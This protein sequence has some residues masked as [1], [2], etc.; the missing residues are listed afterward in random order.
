MAAKPTKRV[1]VLFHARGRDQETAW[2]LPLATSGEYQLD[3]VLFLHETPVCGDVVRAV[4][5]EAQDWQLTFRKIVRR[6]G[7]Y[8][9]VVDYVATTDFALLTKLF[10]SKFEALTEGM[11]SATEGSPGRLYLA[12]PER[13][14]PAA[15]FAAAR[16][17]VPSVVG[18][19]PKV[20]KTRALRTPARTPEV[21][22]KPTSTSLFAAIFKN[23]RARFAKLRPADLLL[24]DDLVRS[25]LFIATLEGRTEIVA[26]LIAAGA[27][28]NP[29]SKKERAP[30]LAAAM[31]N[32]PSE[33]RLL[34]AAGAKLDLASDKDDDLLLVT[35]AFRESVAVLRVFLGETHSPEV[36]SLALL[37]AAGVGHLSLV[38][39]LVK[40]GA[41]PSWKSAKGNTA[42]SI[43]RKR[44]KADIVA[45]SS[46]SRIGARP[47]V[48]AARGFSDRPSEC[49][50]FRL[51]SSLLPSSRSA[52]PSPIRRR[53]R[54]IRSATSR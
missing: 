28:V 44:R 2:C 18:I 47:D 34:L 23:D 25:L 43:A 53:R 8:T 15:V 7:R 1:R 51:F 20:V 11:V 6:G 21:A 13:H 22:A 46:R 39:L 27:P 35:A 36:K 42:L 9:M 24:T 32:R 52:A 31:R 49:A 50:P 37:E 16:E 5:D 14:R 19:H 12:L 30:L 41:D 10:R 29:T 54:R 17:L 33:A 38:K 45:T 40:H 4:V 48:S 26:K 3:N